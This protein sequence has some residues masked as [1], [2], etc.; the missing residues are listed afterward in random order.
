MSISTIALS[1]TPTQNKYNK[2]FYYYFF[3]FYSSIRCSHSITSKEERFILSYW[4]LYKFPI[5][6]LW[7][8]GIISP[9]TTTQEGSTNKPELLLSYRYLINWEMRIVQ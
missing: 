2:Y 3:F 4:I 6:F 7:M 5:V 8:N 1:A 9:Q